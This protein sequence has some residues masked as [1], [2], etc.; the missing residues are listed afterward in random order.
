MA[1]ELSRRGHD[2]LSGVRSKSSLAQLER[3]ADS[4]GVSVDTI[5][6]MQ[7]DVTSAAAASDVRSAI[8]RRGRLDV[9]IHNAGVA[10]TEPTELIAEHAPRLAFE[11]NV[12]GPIRVTQAA[13]PYFR[14]QGHG[15]L[16][17]VSSLTRR[18]PISGPL[19]SVY[20][21]TKASSDAWAVNLNKEVAHHGIRSVIVELG[22]FA[23]DMMDSERF[24]PEDSTPPGSGYE[25]PG[26]Y[27]AATPAAGA[28]AGAAR[29]C[30]LH[31]CQCR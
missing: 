17:T 29:D 3:A 30:G 12:I 1:I 22:G 18:G 13:L 14:A 6:T 4:A 16:V 8:E 26:E 21:A 27:F 5:D 19:N 24:S 23:T 9:L 7:L 2:V 31:H 25:R 10:P 28:H 11:T 15:R 20:A